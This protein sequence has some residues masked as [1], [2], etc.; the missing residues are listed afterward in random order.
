MERRTV[1]ISHIHEEEKL[2]H[3]LKAFVEDSFLKT[4]DVFASSQDDSLRLGDDWNERIKQSLL[5]CDL[6]IVLCSPVSVTRPWINFEAGA[7]WIKGIPVIPLCHSGLT[8]G[9]LR[10]PLNRFQGGVLGDREDI[11]RLFNRVADIV[12]GV[13]PKVD[14]SRMLSATS[15]LEHELINARAKR[16]TEFVRSFLYSRISD[17]KYA[18]TGS[19]HDADVLFEMDLSELLMS[20]DLPFQ[21]IHHMFDAA[22]ISIG[23]LRK[24]VYHVTYEAID[25]MLSEIKFLMSYKEI[26]LPAYLKEIFKVFV[27]NNANA[28]RWYADIEFFADFEKN[29]QVRTTI[30]DMIANEPTPPKMRDTAN[31]INSIIKYWRVIGRIRDWVISYEEFMTQVLGSAHPP[32]EENVVNDNP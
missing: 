16:D 32:D 15:R 20:T 18:V 1:F 14:D 25:E 26:V 12:G 21:D 31:V 24:K 3:A 7:G 11:E 17:L 5:N 29:K 9:A 22:V 6:L 10:A 19:F 28:R 4:L 27:I 30:T 13:P 2:A 8:P 23:S